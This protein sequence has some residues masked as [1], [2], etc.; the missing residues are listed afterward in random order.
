MISEVESVPIF[1]TLTWLGWFTLCDLLA[2][3]TNWFLTCRSASGFFL[4]SPCPRD[5]QLIYISERSSP[6]RIPPARYPT[7]CCLIPVK[8]YMS[9]HSNEYITDSTTG[10]SIRVWTSL[11]KRTTTSEPVDALFYFVITLCIS[12]TMP[13]PPSTSK[14]PVYVK[15]DDGVCED[16]VKN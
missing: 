2:T 10:C 5:L 11:A 6:R 7:C 8:K 14:L 16:N 4:M 12:K 9:N 15:R 13:T 1:W 3:Y